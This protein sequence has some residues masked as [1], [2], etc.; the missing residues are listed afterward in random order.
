MKIKAAGIFVFAGMKRR[1]KFADDIPLCP[2]N[3]TGQGLKFKDSMSI[4][5]QDRGIQ[6]GA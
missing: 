4:W 3:L 6:S 5:P 2:C 1:K